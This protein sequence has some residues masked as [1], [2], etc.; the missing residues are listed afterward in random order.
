MPLEA[1]K[2]DVFCL[3]FVCFLSVMLLNDR[4][5]ATNFA[6]KACNI[7]MVLVS[8]VRGR[9]VVV[10]LHSALSLCHLA[11]PPQTVKL[12]IWPNVGYFPLDCNNRRSR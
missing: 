8:F 9:F 3:I 5:C 6:M 10:H 11:A 2:F 4:V 7:E 1:K 12:K